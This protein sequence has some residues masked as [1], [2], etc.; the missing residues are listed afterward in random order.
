MYTLWDLGSVLIE[1]CTPDSELRKSY[2]FNIPCLK[3]L[4]E[5]EDE[6]INSCIKTRDDVIDNYTQSWD[7]SIYGSA[8]M[9][10]R[11][12]RDCMR[13]AYLLA[14]IA[15]K[16]KESCGE[17]TSNLI[18]DILKRSNALKWIDCRQEKI[19]ELNTK[20]LDYLKLNGDKRKIFSSVF[21]G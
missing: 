21:G 1:L 13:N 3:D 19:E 17:A 10:L 5:T 18:L 12:D 11:M 7:H 4:I 6:N 8:D 15:D 16:T 14:C 20:F 2:L 9:N